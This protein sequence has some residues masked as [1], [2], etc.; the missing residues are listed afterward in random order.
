VSASLDQARQALAAARD[1]LRL[2]HHRDAI[3]RAYYAAFYA[4]REALAEEDVWVKTHRGT[5]TEFSRRFVATGRVEGSASRA[6]RTLHEERTLADY[7]DGDAT[8][9][10]ARDAVET[11]AG[12]LDQVTVLIG[13]TASPPPSDAV[14]PWHALTADQKRDLVAQLTREMDAAAENLEFEK[15]AELRDSITQIEATLAA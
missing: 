8:A 3:S 11:A 2:G 15:A 7:Q 6:L 12:F 14:P 10:Q 9:D 5:V 1:L 4:A 13:D